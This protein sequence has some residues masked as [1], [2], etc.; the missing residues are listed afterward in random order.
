[1]RVLLLARAA[2][3][4][5]AALAR[6]LDGQPGEVIPLGALDPVRGSCRAVRRRRG[7]LRPS[8]STTARPGMRRRAPRS[9][10]PPSDHRSRPVRLPADAAPGRAHRPAGNPTAA[11]PERRLAARQAEDTLLRHEERYWIDTAH[12]AGLDLA[13][14]I[15]RRV[16][17]AATLCGAGSFDD[18][19]ALFGAVP[20][21]GDLTQDQ[22]HRLDSW[23]SGLYPPDT[24]Q[25]WGSLQPDRLGEYL[26]AT[27][28]PDVPGLLG[29]LLTATDA[30]RHHR[31]LT[32]LARAL[33]NPAL[34]EPAATQLSDAGPRCPRRRSC[35]PGSG[36]PAGDHR[37]RE[38]A[39]NALGPSATPPRRPTRPSS[40]NS[41]TRCR[42]PASRWPTWPHSGRRAGLPTY[43]PRRPEAGPAG[44]NFQHNLR[45]ADLANSLTGQSA[46]LADLGRPR[47]GAGRQH[48]GRRHL[49]GASRR[50]HRQCVARRCTSAPAGWRIWADTRRRWPSSTWSSASFGRFGNRR[51]R[52]LA[53]FP[54]G[55]S[56]FG[57]SGHP[58]RRVPPQPGPGADQ[59]SVSLAALGRRE[60]ALAAS[61]EAVTTYRELAGRPRPD[62]FTPD[63]AR[64]LINQSNA[65]AG[66]GRYEE[67][68]AASTEA[69][70]IGRGLAA[71]RPDAFTPDL[72][73]A[74]NNQSVDL[75]ELGRREEAL[76]ASTEALSTYRALATAHPDA[77]TP[78]LARALSN[79][80][81]ALAELGRYEE[82]LT[83]STEAVT[84]YRELAAARPDAFTPDLARALNNQSNALAELGRYEEALAAS[85]EAVTTYRALRDAAE[86]SSS[87]GVTPGGFYRQR[88]PS[89]P[90]W[91]GR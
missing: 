28:L 75:A 42:N 11:R 14:T 46:R 33:G 38:P 40:I 20:G 89:P 4:W 23:L 70:T 80:S 32:I 37:N 68:L 58:A 52:V 76:A 34:T 36:R 1:M 18:A 87:R 43:A 62:A 84:V 57:R 82:A 3:E 13:A 22:L 90:T 78:D 65:L 31:A 53:G 60:E 39:T 26:I 16:V 30:A 77:F 74:L 2:G 67:A 73:L 10:R 85:T 86:P 79:Q 12:S 25:R 9:V 45:M 61:T 24:G 71:A 41:S 54:G 88:M 59:P 8:A 21:T 5:W 56:R 72:A 15:L 48:R 69:V 81:N 29:A 44:G 50:V 35:P 6:D 55:R 63:L 27:T 49:S 17:A 91:P 66:L 51:G 7:G 83:A 19:S 47:G 64:A